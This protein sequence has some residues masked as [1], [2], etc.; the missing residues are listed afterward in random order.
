MQLFAALLAMEVEETGR[1]VPPVSVLRI[2][3]CDCARSLRLCTS[4][5]PASLVITHVQ[6]QCVR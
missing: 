6:F 4:L 1:L 2:R 5:R 3:H